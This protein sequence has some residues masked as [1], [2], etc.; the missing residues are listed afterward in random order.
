MRKFHPERRQ[1]SFSAKP[2]PMRLVEGSEATGFAPPRLDDDARD[3]STA[4][5]PE[6]TRHDGPV[7]QGARQKSA[8]YQFVERRQYAKSLEEIYD[9][10]LE[11]I[12]SA[13]RCDRAAI[14]LC[15]ETNVMR[16]V[17][18]RELSDH[19]RATIESHSLCADPHPEPVCVSNLANAKLDETIKAV[20]QVEGIAGVAF[21][22]LVSNRMLAGKFVICYNAPHAFDAD[23]LE[24]ALTIAGQLA[25][26]IE[27]LRAQA[28]LRQ[29]EERFRTLVSI[30]TEVP[31]VM[32]T[33]GAFTTPQTVWEAYTG[34]N[35]EQH[36]GFGWISAIHPEDRQR[37]E[38]V[39][40]SAGANRTFYQCEARLWHAATQRWRYI[41][42][43]AVPLLDELGAVHEWIGACTDIDDQKRINEELENK[44]AEQTL[45]LRQANQALVRDIEEREK[46]EEQLLQAQKMESIGRLAGGIA[47]DF[48]NIL[49]IIL[50]YVFILRG[51]A[52][53][54]KYTSQSLEVISETV[55]RGSGLVQQLLTLARK[56]P[57]KLE[58]VNINAVIEGLS[59]LLKQTFPK[60]IELSTIL[61]PDLS[62]ISADRNQI[63]QALLNLCVNAGDAMPNGG[64][65]I[66]RT[67]SVDAAALHPPGHP[68]EGRYVCVEVRDTGTGME[69]AVRE[70]IFEPFFTTKEKGQGTGLGLSV[71]YGIVNSHN[72]MIDVDS[73]PQRGTCFTLRFPVAAA[74]LSVQEAPLT[75]GTGSEAAPIA[76]AS[77]LLVEDEPH[78]LELLEKVFLR[79]GYRVFTAKD[80]NEA[81]TIYRR[82]KDL[83]DSILL[84]IGLP[85]MA[86]NDVLHLMRQENPNLKVVI[87]SGYLEPDLK[88][89]IEKVELQHYCFLQKPYMPDDVVKAF[90]RLE[91][92]P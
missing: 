4:V 51:S 73:K 20:A 89:K 64:R 42:V 86:G 75:N 41:T 14:L 33:S 62:P 48:N 28:A 18:W 63:E 3:E 43:R 65:L 58:Q 16:F 90:Q 31:W 36:R 84:D 21:I 81:V 5:G 85:K 78:M 1:G 29:S 2:L 40:R 92:Q 76:G 77:V 69:E 87:A 74:G 22:P 91:S 59:A 39:W 57:V 8:L 68:I 38:V 7:A 49:N 45:E 25:L 23:E 56:T 11:A 17:A 30:I 34:Q 19:Y 53:V 35:W 50:G 46:L 60:T 67:R 6:H 32:D 52:M 27:H 15:D 47:H 10:A 9:I 26:D 80:G 12:R 79:R 83:I 55:Q 24:L 61:E 70:R 13:L 72:G 82:H 54:D 88:A 66:F 71:V 44:V 37:V